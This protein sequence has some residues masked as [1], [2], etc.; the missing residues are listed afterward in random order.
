MFSTDNTAVMDRACVVSETVD[1]VC[2]LV[3]VTP[4]HVGTW[5]CF[6]PHLCHHTDTGHLT[7]GTRWTP[8]SQLDSPQ[9]RTPGC[10]LSDSGGHSSSVTLVSRH[11][12]HIS[13]HVSEHQVH[14]MSRPMVDTRSSQSGARSRSSRWCWRYRS[15]SPPVVDIWHWY[16]QE[17][18]EL[19]CSLVA[20][21][22]KNTVII[23][24]CYNNT[25]S[26]E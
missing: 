14:M 21:S 22:S 9:C 19:F 24:Y 13:G 20:V 26:V 7:T 16:G 3:K 23:L 1:R 6:W 2:Q 18:G 12:S 17:P 4:P 15:V 10:H 8:D 11:S 25:I 5:S